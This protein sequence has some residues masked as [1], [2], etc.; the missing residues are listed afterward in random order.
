MVRCRSVYTAT[1][2]LVE[3]KLSLELFYLAI[4]IA[5]FAITLVLN[6]T[7]LWPFWLNLIVK[8]K[9]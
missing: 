5:T 2:Y 6:T 8:N 4:F 1:V 9:S 7:T 3:Q